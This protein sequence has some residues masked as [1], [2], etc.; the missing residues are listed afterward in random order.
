MELGMHGS[1]VGLP[2]PGPAHP[3]APALCSGWS[4]SRAE[5]LGSRMG[6]QGRA[7]WRA[8]GWLLRTDLAGQ[9][10]GVWTAT[11]QLCVT[12]SSAGYHLAA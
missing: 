8:E 3:A 12:V 11:P 2:T 6:L 7:T 1:I 5:G 9:V 10:A 4:G